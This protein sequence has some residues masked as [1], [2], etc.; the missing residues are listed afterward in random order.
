MNANRT[1]RLLSIGML[2]LGACSPV[3]LGAR[4]IQ[5]SGAVDTPSVWI[6]LQ[7]NDGHANGI[8]RCYEVAGHRP[9]CRQADMDYR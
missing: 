3:T 4:A 1:R 6:Y 2:A 8:Y 9:L 7:T 5:P